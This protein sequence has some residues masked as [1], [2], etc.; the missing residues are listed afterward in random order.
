MTLGSPLATAAA[1]P[2]GEDLENVLETAR[3]HDAPPAVGRRHAQSLLDQGDLR[4]A[5][6]ALVEEHGD[7]I[8]AFCLRT[9]RSPALAEDVAQQVFVHALRDIARFQGRSTWLVWLIGIAA[10]RCMD[11]INSERRRLRRI[12][13]N[14][15]A[16]LGIPDLACSLSDRLDR[17]WWIEALEK[18]LGVLASEV[19]M[20]VLLRFQSGMSYPEMSEVLG[21]RSETLQARVARALPV[22]RRCLEGKGWQDD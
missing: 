13:L 20:T 19:R 4:G 5:V 18:C 16:T 22:L 14:D 17:L 3:A 9:L 11:A 6:G 2:A 1:A 15:Q 12:D 10:H 21:V 7:A 8:Y